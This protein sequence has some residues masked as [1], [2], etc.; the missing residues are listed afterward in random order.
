MI[1]NDE[2]PR[3]KKHVVMKCNSQFKGVTLLE[4]WLVE[5][6]EGKGKSAVYKWVERDE[7]DVHADHI[8]FVGD[9][10]NNSINIR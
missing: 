9:L 5:E 8:R 6:A 3:M 10:L 2:F 7:D 4:G 1:E